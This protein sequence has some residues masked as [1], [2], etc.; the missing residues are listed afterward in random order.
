MLGG[1]DVRQPIETTR[2]ALDR[3]RADERRK[4]VARQA[5][6]TM[7]VEMLTEVKVLGLR[8]RAAGQKDTDVSSLFREAMAKFLAKGD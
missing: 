2:D 6:I 4:L 3:P 8:R 7:P 5:A 1:L